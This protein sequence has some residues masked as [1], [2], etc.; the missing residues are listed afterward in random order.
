MCER[1]MHYFEL[2]YMVYVEKWIANLRSAHEMYLIVYQ[3]K[4]NFKARKCTDEYQ[5]YFKPAL[6]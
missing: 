3:G 1:N 6:S 5:L 4:M 2:T